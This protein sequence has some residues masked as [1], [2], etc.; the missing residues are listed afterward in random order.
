MSTHFGKCPLALTNPTS[1]VAG[2]EKAPCLHSP[3]DVC[4]TPSPRVSPLPPLHVSLCRCHGGHDQC[5]QLQSGSLHPSL[6]LNDQ[7]MRKIIPSSFLVASHTCTP[8]QALCICAL[9]CELH[10]ACRPFLQSS[11]ARQHSTSP[12]MSL[13]ML[14]QVIRACYLARGSSQRSSISSKD[15][16]LRP[17][18]SQ[19]SPR[20][21][22]LSAGLPRLPP[23]TAPIRQLALTAPVL[24]RTD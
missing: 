18:P 19:N 10:I 22:L 8:W 13:A 4:T 3:Q 24:M 16:T 9:P 15:T 12:R 2:S 1:L 17:I 14:I 20:P 11:S 5:T 6:S 21:V 7:G 23:L